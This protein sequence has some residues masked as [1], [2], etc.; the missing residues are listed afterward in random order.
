MIV[1]PPK[2][3]VYPDVP[4]ATY[5]SWRA[6]NASTLKVVGRRSPSHAYHALHHPR[7][8][9]P[10]LV[11]GEAAHAAILEP[12]R[13]EEEYCRGL[14]IG[15]RS[16]ADKEAW[17]VFEEANAGK[18]VLSADDYDH[19]NEMRQAL[20]K[21]DTA[22]ELLETAGAMTEIS[23]V[24]DDPELGCP[25]KARAD[26][27]STLHGWSI[28][29]DLKTTQNAAPDAFSRSIANYD[30]HVQ[31]A[32]YLDGAEALAP[33]DRRFIFIAV[34]KTPPFGVSCVELDERSLESG[35][36]LYRRWLRAWSA[37][38]AS[39]KYEGYGAAVSPVSLPA[40]AQ[41]DWEEDPI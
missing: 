30:Y 14:G 11:I 40:Y 38:V 9:T 26:L 4:A 37:A 18:M 23:L 21:H 29:G 41:V 39:G 19:C 25:C 3:G 34:E 5:H 27:F 10:A 12:A 6:A 2:S 32:W 13:F 15:K 35:R 33:R 36:T 16:K 8:P 1:D 24:W 28:L 17:K 31:A 22:A 20:L 7:D